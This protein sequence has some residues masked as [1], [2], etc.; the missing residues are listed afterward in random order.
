MLPPAGPAAPKV[1]GPP[2]PQPEI[3]VW[4]TKD[5]LS[6]AP[7]D[8]KQRSVGFVSAVGSE[9]MRRR[10]DVSVASAAIRLPGVVLSRG[11]QTAQA[12]YP[13]IRGFDGR[14]SSVTLDGSMLYLSTRNQRGVPLDF[15][16]AAAINEI[17]IN[18]TVTPEMDPNSIGGHIEI[19]TLRVFDND[20]QPLTSLDAQAVNYA[21]PG[22][23]R[24]GNPSY[25]LNGVMKRTFGANGDFGFVLAGS[26]HRDQFNEI[27]NSTT[28]LIQQDGV[29]IP[30]GNLLTGNYH[31]RQHGASFLGKL[32]GRG[33]RW[34]GYLAAN[35]FE[36]HIR[37]D[38]S[39][40]NISITPAL[41]TDATEGTGRFSGAAPNALSNFIFNDRHVFSFRTGGEYQTNDRSKIVLNASYLHV[42]YKEQL[43][44][45]API[46]GPA[47]SGTYQITDTQAGTRIEG[48]AALRDPTQWT[49]GSDVTATWPIYPLTDNIY[50]ARLEY[51]SNNFDFSKG[52]GYDVGID[53]RRL[54]RV[55][56]QS[57]YNYTLPPGTTIN[58][59]QV[60]IPGSPFDGSD[61]REPIYV[62]VNRYWSLLA[63][64]GARTL[65]PGTT[66]DYDLRED[67][68]APFVSFYYTT[69]RFRVLAGARYNITR[70]TDSTHQIVDGQVTPFHITRSLPYLLPNVQGYFNFSDALRVR[71][72]FTVTTA[73]QDFSNFANGRAVG[74]DYKGNRVINNTNPYLRPRRSYNKDVSIELYRPKGYF[75]LGYFHKTI[76]D[77]VQVVVAY[78]YDPNGAL[79]QIV[80]YPIN[81]GGEHVQGIE[82]ESQWRDFSNLA[83]W[84]KGVTL[85][86][87]GAWFDSTTRVVV[88]ADTERTVKGFR[89]QPKWVVNMILTY[90][91]GP[92]S[93]ALIGMVRGRALNSIATTAPN[94]L[95]I[96]PFATLDAKFAY[97]VNRSLKLYVEGKNLTNS[98]YREVTGTHANLV[99]TAIKDGPTIVMGAT[100]NF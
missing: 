83:P 54:H 35:Y 58:L 36:E 46:S 71:A 13:A 100:L 5:R 9:E 69:D 65:D 40:S 41:V 31:R 8:E 14:Y 25:T 42:N 82:F 89:L 57:T 37:E 15:L 73:L 64:L 24:S 19:R 81:A 76:V 98:W 86:V 26:A 70:Y 87:N 20:G 72:A 97:R 74:F 45:G 67:V 68:I 90:D 55:L 43:L 51:K 4:G 66:A 79:T 47:V 52:V 44:T 33:D 23:L 99:S 17:V 39:R 10:T 50:T 60:L 84:L 59:G 1:E 61:P 62:D 2:Q 96:A 77:E 92:F 28:A 30:S 85:D 53:F 6:P 95:Y 18:K 16:P 27:I 94:D 38:L 91:R 56:D 12:W 93:G 11:T 21:Q 63:S 88:G 3:I 75:S 29:D 49:Q 32:E 34:Y 48:P 78:E 80:Q 7:Q 22:S